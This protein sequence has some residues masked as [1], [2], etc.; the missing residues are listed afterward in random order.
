M[1]LY[2]KKYMLTSLGHSNNYYII[3]TNYLIGLDNLIIKCQMVHALQFE[4]WRDALVSG[5]VCCN[6][7]RLT[8][9]A[10]ASSR[11]TSNARGYAP[12]YS[13][14]LE[15][16]QNLLPCQRIQRGVDGRRVIWGGQCCVDGVIRGLGHVV[17]RRDVGLLVL[18]GSARG[19]C[20]PNWLRV[21]AAARVRS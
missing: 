17:N 18:G 9:G 7:Q 8:I 20:G 15:H 21:T 14:S 10:L 4:G 11:T 19:I 13:C 6:D 12:S 3:A 1:W 16:F 2:D 5:T